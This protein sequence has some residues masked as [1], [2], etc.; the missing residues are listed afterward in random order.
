MV[1]DPVAC[2]YASVKIDGEDTN[3]RLDDLGFLVS[4]GHDGVLY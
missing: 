2:T 1:E 4:D 3:V